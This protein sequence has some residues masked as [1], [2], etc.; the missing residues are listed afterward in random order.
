MGRSNLGAGAVCPPLPPC[1]P[2][3]SLAPSRRVQVELEHAEGAPESNWHQQHPG[4]FNP[5]LAPLFHLA[6]GVRVGA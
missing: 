3:L 1:P 4:G 2:A 6:D 5:T